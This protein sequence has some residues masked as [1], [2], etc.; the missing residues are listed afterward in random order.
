MIPWYIEI[1]YIIITIVVVGYV[2]SGV[3]RF[4]RPQTTD[5]L[6]NRYRI[7]DWEEFKWGVMIAAPGIVLHEMGHKFVGLSFGLN[8]QYEIWIMGLLIGVILRA[9]NTGFIM[10]APGFVVIAGATSYQSAAT[11]FAGP[12]VN[13]ILWLSSY[14]ILKYHKKLTPKTELILIA[15]EKINMWLFIF[16]MIPIPPL[17]G[18]KVFA[19]LFNLLF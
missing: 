11:A 4:Q 14:A 10:L 1:L 16:N 7:F 5:A 19:P 2:F 18:S 3:I 12:A 6:F 9:L 17:D 8:A 15:T 13:L